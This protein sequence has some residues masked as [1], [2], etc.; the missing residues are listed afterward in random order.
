[1]KP[2]VCL[3]LL[4]ATIA[5]CGDAASGGS[6]GSL[7]PPGQIDVEGTSVPEKMLASIDEESPFVER[8][9]VRRFR[10]LLDRIE[11]SCRDGRMR[12]ADYATNAMTILDEEKGVSVST[13][14]V[15]EAVADVA[16]TTEDGST[17]CR[18]TFAAY[19][20]VTGE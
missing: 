19:I 6:G 17:T 10:F 7:T 3:A 9:L 18:D 12:L 14:D 13:Q 5:G 11:E 8:R 1:M 15:L 20:A 2:V 4:A 16:A